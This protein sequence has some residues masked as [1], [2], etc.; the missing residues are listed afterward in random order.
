M[1][2]SEVLWPSMS[3]LSDL[4]VLIPKGNKFTFVFINLTL[5]PEHD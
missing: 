3:R 2:L 5:D 4:W 1:R